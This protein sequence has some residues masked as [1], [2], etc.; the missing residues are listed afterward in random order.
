MLN[1][2]APSAIVA[3][4]MRWPHLGQGGLWIDP[5]DGPDVWEY[6]SCMRC[7]LQIG[8]ERYGTLSHR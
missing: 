4:L 6:C 3:K 8:R 5:S 2:D 1:A 7:T